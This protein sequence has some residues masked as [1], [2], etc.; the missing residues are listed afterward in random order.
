MQKPKLHLISL[1]CVKNLVDSEVMLGVLKEYSLTDD[2]EIADLIVINTCGFIEAAKKESLNTILEANNLRKRSSVLAVAGCLTERYKDE[3]QKLIP[4]VDIF[5]GLGDYP[6]IKSLIEEK[7]SKFSDDI[8]LIDKETR[9]I[10]GSNTHA[11]IKISEGCNQKCSFCAITNFKGNLHSRSI[12]SVVNEIQSLVAKGFFDFSIVAQDSS[13]YLLDQKQKNALCQLISQVEQIK[14]VKKARILYLYPSTTNKTLINAIA[15]SKVFENYFDMPIQH[16]SNKMLRIMNRGMLKTKT[17]DLIKHI[18]N[19]PNAWL[20]TAFIVGHPGESDDDFNELLEFIDQDYFDF[21]SVFEYSN[22]E[23]TKAFLM[24]QVP[25]KIIKQRMKKIENLINKKQ[26]K[27]LQTLKNTQITAVING[28]SDEHEF[29]LSAKNLAWAPGIDPEII[30]NESEK[31]LEIGS[32]V[33]A[34]ITDII[35]DKLLAKVLK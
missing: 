21:I 29:L 18:K 19:V 9:I 16:I 20:R 1:G 24:P 22:E 2:V 7:Q 15:R 12:N 10:T 14:G 5:T 6:K 3:I 35:G 17:L 26:T 31:S 23:D 27:K 13:S 4:E 25:K 34:K 33:N 8:F 32:L 28:V 30:I 11:Y